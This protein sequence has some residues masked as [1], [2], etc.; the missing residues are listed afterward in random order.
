M[1]FCLTVEEP[2]TIL[3]LGDECVCCQ[4]WQGIVDRCDD[5]LSE[6]AGIQSGEETYLQVRQD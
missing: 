4:V 2:L 1:F 6:Y 3:P 5:V